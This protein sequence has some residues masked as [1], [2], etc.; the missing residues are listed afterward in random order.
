MDNA[1]NLETIYDQKIKIIA[2]LIL[3]DREGYVLIINRNKSVNDQLA[4]IGQKLDIMDKNNAKEFLFKYRQAASDESE[5][6]DLLIEILRRLPLAIEQTGGF[7]REKDISIARYRALYELNRSEALKKGLSTAHKETY[8]R[9]IVAKT[10]DISFK[11]IEQMD[12]LVNVILWISAFL[13]GKQSRK[14]CFTA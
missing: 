5:E 12:P 14:I 3:K 2:N 13:D 8:Y 10:W 9:E 6:V 7:I 1:D 4:I 11:A